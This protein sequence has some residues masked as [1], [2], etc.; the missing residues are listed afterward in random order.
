[1]RYLVIGLGIYGSNLARNL[2]SM[3]HEVIGADR[4]ASIVQALKDDLSTVYCVDSTDP[5]ALDVLPFR[6]VDLVIVAI[7]EN[8]GASVKTVALLR[9]NKVQHIYARAIDPLHHAILDCFDLDRILTPEQRAASD[10]AIELQLGSDVR[11]LRLTPDTMAISFT[12]PE[13]FVGK[14]YL[15]LNLT[16]YGLALVGATRGRKVMGLLGIESMQRDTLFS[17]AVPQTG[18]LTVENGDAWLCLGS[19]RALHDMM[20]HIS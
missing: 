14:E 15:D 9:Q 11:T 12:A 4:N 3:G 18:H 10:L 2:V 8:F 7:G 16:Q 5:S 6:N 17:G 19:S 20:R 13:F 1:M